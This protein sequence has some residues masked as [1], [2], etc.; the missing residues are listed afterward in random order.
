[1]KRL[2]DLMFSL[3]GRISRKTFWIYYATAVVAA[4]VPTALDNST[5][6]IMHPDFKSA[7]L[8]VFGVAAVFLLLWGIGNIA[9]SV[10]RLHDLNKSG[11]L[12]F[13]HFIPLFGTLGLLFYLGFFPS[14]H[15][16]TRHGPPAN[17]NR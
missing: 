11:L 12:L 7:E 4:A 3:K 17:N 15:G 5:F 14:Y 2:F 8:A 1:M 10:K 13:F 16:Y 9:V 6:T